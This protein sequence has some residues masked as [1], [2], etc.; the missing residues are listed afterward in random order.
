M[1]EKGLGLPIYEIKPKKNVIKL[2]KKGFFLTVVLARPRTLFPFH[3]AHKNPLNDCHFCFDSGI[4]SRLH[5]P[6]ISTA[7]T[8][9]ITYE[10]VFFFLF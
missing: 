4:G 3:C 9:K 10:I 2:P 7:H 1:S 6:S 5:L 8:K